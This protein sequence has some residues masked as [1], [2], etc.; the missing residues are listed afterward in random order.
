M[1]K[2]GKYE[3]QK[4]I[5]I[6]WDPVL[7]VTQEGNLAYEIQRELNITMGSAADKMS[8]LPDCTEE[9]AEAISA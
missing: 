6:K 2:L 3:K 1:R 7:R 9:T 4:I 5:S 8:F